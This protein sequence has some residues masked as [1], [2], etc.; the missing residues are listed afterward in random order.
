MR[1][2]DIGLP[3]QEADKTEVTVGLRLPKK[4]A[5]RVK[6]YMETSRARSFSAAVRELVRKGLLEEGL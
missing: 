1:L 2:S 4:D 3:R 6:I 5:E